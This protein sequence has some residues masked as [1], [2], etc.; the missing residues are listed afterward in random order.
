MEKP[1]LE[2]KV[3]RCVDER[4]ETVSV[5]FKRYKRTYPPSLVGKILSF[6]DTEND[7]FRALNRLTVEVLVTKTVTRY[8]DEE[9]LKEDVALFQLSNIGRQQLLKKTR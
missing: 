7:I 3:L 8:L 2:Q 1:S 4:A 5:I 9:A 6:N